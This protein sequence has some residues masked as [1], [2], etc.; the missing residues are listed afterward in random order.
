MCY[1][2]IIESKNVKESLLDEFWVNVMQEELE[3]FTW[4]DVWTLVT[5]L[6]HTNAIGTK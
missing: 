4:N 1:N 3:Q 2:S 5:R 6:N